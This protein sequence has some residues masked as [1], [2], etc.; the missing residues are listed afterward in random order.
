MSFA[1]LRRFLRKLWP[2]KD[3]VTTDLTIRGDD[4]GWSVLPLR[5]GELEHKARPLPGGQ[6]VEHEVTLRA[7]VVCHYCRR[8]IDRLGDPCPYKCP[9]SEDLNDV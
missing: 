7:V 4:P 2:S 9:G 1:K 5:E 8:P 6:L 3:K